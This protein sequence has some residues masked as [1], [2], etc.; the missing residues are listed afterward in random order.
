MAD[1]YD[2]QGFLDGPVGS[3]RCESLRH[4][5]GEWDDAGCR[6]GPADHFLDLLGL[7]AGIPLR[8]GPFA[9]IFLDIHEKIDALGNHLQQHPDETKDQYRNPQQNQDGKQNCPQRS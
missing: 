6:R 5:D 7:D 4:G 2:F 1:L 9:G 3:E 8:A